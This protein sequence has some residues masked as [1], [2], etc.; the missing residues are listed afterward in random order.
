MEISP[1]LGHTLASAIN[2]DRHVPMLEAA[3]R[4]TARALDANESLI[5]DMVRKR[6]SWVLKLASL[7]EK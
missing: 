2:E 7:D 5:R 1:L 3:I 6:V 4:W